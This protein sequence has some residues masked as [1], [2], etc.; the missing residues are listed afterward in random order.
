MRFL[1]TKA[2]FALMAVTACL[3][4]GTV[5]AHA[6][7]IFSTTAVAGFSLSMDN[8]VNAGEDQIPVDQKRQQNNNKIH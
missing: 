7:S 5:Q 1:K 2:S 3:G 4:A 6:E 8:I